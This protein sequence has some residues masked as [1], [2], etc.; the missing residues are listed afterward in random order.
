MLGQVVFV[1]ISNYNGHFFP[2][3]K[4]G[5]Q[6]SH[7][8]LW[9]TSYEWIQNQNWQSQELAKTSSHPFIQ[10]KFHSFQDVSDVFVFRGLRRR[11]TQPS[12]AQPNQGNG[13]YG[14]SRNSWLWR[15][16]AMFDLICFVYGQSIQSSFQ[17]EIFRL[18]L[19]QKEIPSSA[20]FSLKYSNTTEGII[21][22]DSDRALLIGFEW[23]S[24][25]CPRRISLK[26]D[27]SNLC[28]IIITI[29]VIG[30][31][32]G[33]ILPLKTNK[34]PLTHSLAIDPKTKRQVTSLRKSFLLIII[35]NFIVS[36]QI[37]QITAPRGFLTSPKYWR[38]FSYH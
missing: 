37:S 36:G 16:D 14:T 26:L 20:V 9:E 6:T 17:S 13:Y 7:P 2:T 25:L 5:K 33:I 31:E 3:L 29:A 22:L 28:R 38:N 21:F 12:R 24:N 18:N 27:I 35:F 11:E 10:P 1:G 32:V 15:A 19:K 34:L 4:E 23:N 8:L 30:Q